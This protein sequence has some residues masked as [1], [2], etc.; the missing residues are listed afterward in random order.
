MV[1]VKVQD[2]LIVDVTN[3]RNESILHEVKF[4]NQH[5]Q[6]IPHEDDDHED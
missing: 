1:Y 3:D 4:L 5:G 2:G 6:E